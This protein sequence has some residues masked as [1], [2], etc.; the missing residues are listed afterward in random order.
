M[1]IATVTTYVMIVQYLNLVPLYFSD[2]DILRREM[3]NES[4]RISTYILS[5]IMYETPMAILQVLLL[6]SLGYWLVDLNSEPQYVLYFG[7]LLIIGV[8]AW[9]SMV[10]LASF[11]TNRIGIVYTVC[12]VFLGLGTLFGGLLIIKKISSPSSSHFST[13]PSQHS[14]TEPSSTM[15]FY[16]VT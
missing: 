9:Q 6:S 3:E 2:R 7:L 5:S 12:F 16:V 4:S 11:V 14:P 15:I 13:P 8:C 10:C 1:F